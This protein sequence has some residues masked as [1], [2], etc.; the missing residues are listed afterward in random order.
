LYGS[1]FGHLNVTSQQDAMMIDGAR[2]FTDCI[3]EATLAAEEGSQWQAKRSL[4]ERSKKHSRPV[5]MPD[6]PPLKG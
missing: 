2:R 6:L 5:G 3:L 4:W 1:D